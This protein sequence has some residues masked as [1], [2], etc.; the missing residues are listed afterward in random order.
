M[1]GSRATAHSSTIVI[2]FRPHMQQHFKQ[3]HLVI[4]TRIKSYDKD[5]KTSRA[6]RDRRRLT[7]TDTSKILPLIPLPVVPVV[8]EGIIKSDAEDVDALAGPG[9][10]GE[11][12]PDE[13][14]TQI[15]PGSGAVSLDGIHPA[16]S[17]LET[18]S[19]W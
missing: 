8:P 13:F 11:R 2:S 15:V 3:T 12:I 4:D 10:G 14:A 18:V 17:V 16:A 9:H 5:I 1:S 7:N 19:G 6:S